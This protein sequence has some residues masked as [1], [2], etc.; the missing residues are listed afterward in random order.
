MMLEI[1]LL[2]HW[3]CVP[4]NQHVH[5]P[6]VCLLPQQKITTCQFCL[7]ATT[8]FYFCLHVH[9][10]FRDHL[11]GG[12]CLSLLRKDNCCLDGSLVDFF[13][14]SELPR[15]LDESVS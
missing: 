8:H 11:E 14:T 4:I 13:C 3:E 5:T 9:V 1:T 12:Y 2:H 15:G 10:A 6:L 7:N